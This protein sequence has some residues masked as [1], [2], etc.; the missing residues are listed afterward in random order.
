MSY[1]HPEDDRV[2]RHGPRARR[3]YP[4]GTAAALGVGLV[5]LGGLAAQQFAPRRMPHRPPDSAPGRTSRQSRYGD[6]AVTGRSVTINKPRQEIYDFWR[7]F[8]NLARFMENVESVHEAGDVTVWT[9]AAPAGRSVEVR[10]RIV[11]D[12]PGEEIAWRATDDSEIDTEGKVM[13]RDAPGDRG[14]VVE[15]VIAYK[16]PMGELGRLAAKLFQAEP[17]VQARRDLKRLKMLLETG[18]IAT[19]RNRTDS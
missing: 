16:P 3:R 14:T 18:E 19:N 4:R 2:A 8:S 13:F 6:Y 11:Q 7:D 5:L 17:A 9:I 12:R 10:T 15:A 1:I